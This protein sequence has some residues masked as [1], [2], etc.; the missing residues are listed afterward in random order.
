MSILPLFFII[1]IFFTQLIKRPFLEKNLKKIFWIPVV[2]VF[3]LSTIFSFL[4]YRAWKENKLMQFVFETDGGFSGF[5]YN[6][7]MSY[8]APYIL[9][10]FLAGI[11]VL[12]MFIINKRSGYRFFEREEIL[13]AF[14]ASFLVCFP[15][16][17]FFIFGIVIAYLFTHIISVIIKKSVRGNV[18]PLY[19]FWLPVSGSVIITEMIWLSKLGFWSL[20]SV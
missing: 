19:Y 4:Q 20:L 8:Y 10:L 15:G 9:S 6:A 3:S 11:L 18:I 14:L 12:L 17:L 2:A 1:V 7:F 5:L 16:F 13:I